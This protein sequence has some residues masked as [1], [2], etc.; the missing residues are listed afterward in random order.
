M[1]GRIQDAITGRFLSPDPYVGE[2]TFTQGY[3]RYSYVN[4]NP[5]S[6]TDPTGF[7]GQQKTDQSQEGIRLYEIATQFSFDP[8]V[9]LR[10]L[11]YSDFVMTGSRI[12]LTYS[13]LAE[14]PI[15]TCA[16]G[17]VSS[18]TIWGADGSV[19]P[20][21]PP[22]IRQTFTPGAKTTHQ[23]PQHPITT[24]GIGLGNPAPQGGSTFNRVAETLLPIGA[25]LCFFDAGTP[26][27]CSGGKSVAEGIGVGAAI[28]PGG[29]L[30][31]TVAGRVFARIAERTAARG[32]GEALGTLSR[33]A[34][35]GGG[36]LITAA[37]TI[38]QDHVAPFVEEA[39]R[40]GRQVDILTGVHGAPNGS[41]QMSVAMFQSDVRAFGGLPGVTVHD[42]SEL[43]YSPDAIRSIVNGPNTV[44]GAFC[45][46]GACLAPFR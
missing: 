15:A 7:L 31:G 20:K 26:S 35:A 33:S 19:M 8:S 32:A 12:P 1:N 44:I 21:L 41:M 6:Y 13:E 2:P 46:S 42:M 3:N 24:P 14:C 29:K 39:V 18:F 10:G 5:L 23:N 40:M 25:F 11:G 45:D 28:L 9:V 34:T 16:P 17:G 30:L 37:G 27:A 43:M 38:T 36:E 22:A 4:N